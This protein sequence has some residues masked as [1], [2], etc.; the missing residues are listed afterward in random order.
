MS[1]G[2]ISKPAVLALSNG[3]RIAGCWM[4]TGE[5]GAD[6]VFQIGTAKYGVRDETGKLSDDKLRG[7][8]AHETS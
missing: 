1:F 7:I 8:A 2:A 4:S 5:G 3:A 6:I